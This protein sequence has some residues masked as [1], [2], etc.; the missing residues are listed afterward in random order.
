MEIAFECGWS[1][2]V[3]IT[4]E[5]NVSGRADIS[6]VL[7]KGGLLSPDD[8]ARVIIPEVQGYLRALRK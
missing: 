1:V 7:F 8:C 6:T 2:E 4:P 5:P 3:R